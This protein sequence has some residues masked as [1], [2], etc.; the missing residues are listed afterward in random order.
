MAHRFCRSILQPLPLNVIVAVTM[1]FSASGVGGTTSL[2]G[3]PTVSPCE[4]S[5]RRPAVRQTFVRDPVDCSVFYTC[6]G[7]RYWSRTCPVA[8]TV[9]SLRYKVCVWRNSVYDD[10][11]SVG[12][13]F[14]TG[15]NLIEQKTDRSD[16]EH[17]EDS[18]GLSDS[19]N[20]W[21]LRRDLCDTEAS[22]KDA[23]ATANITADTNHA[24]DN[25]DDIDTSITATIAGYVVSENSDDNDSDDD[26]DDEH[27][28][29]LARPFIIGGRR[30]RPGQWPW[31][32]SLQV[33][34][35]VSEPWHRCGG[36]L[37]H[38]GWVLTAAH[39]VEGPFYGNVKN[40]RVVLA[41]DN[42]EE[43][44]G[45]EIYRNIIRIISHPGYIRTSNFPND[46]AL[47]QLDSEVDLSSGEVR[48]ACLPDLLDSPP[49]LD[50]CWISGWGETRGG[51]GEEKAMN[52]L[53]VQP[54]DNDVCSPLWLSVGIHVLD[55]QVCVGDGHMGACYGDSGG[56]LMCQ[57]P[58]GRFYVTGVMS[59]LI[60]NCSARGFPNVF[61]RV[62]S[63]LDWVYEQLDFHEWFR[64][65]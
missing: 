60:N 2:Y 26:N 27:C 51:E 18:R 47:L 14:H 28:G 39:C 10:C 7:N 12:S 63:Y 57:Q 48:V 55:H 36:V 6:F 21:S 29:I 23:T 52:E 56:P 22:F 38:P 15:S 43:E 4:V 20:T 19:R 46:M 3:S 41:E 59:W 58:D 45:N 53:P 44:S 24:V 13:D 1:L 40:W 49:D 54:I 37:I 42:L 35:A 17:V 62:S 64:Y 33:S 11:D 65:N 34:V 32:V 9:Y 25:N 50:N 8:G 31:Q 61:S 5:G 16:V 30:S